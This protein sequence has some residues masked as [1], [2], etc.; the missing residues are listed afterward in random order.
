MAVTKKKNG[1]YRA[2][3][4]VFNNGKQKRCRPSFDR[5]KDAENFEADAVKS[6]QMRS[7]FS[8]LGKSLR[9]IPE[10]VDYY[11][12]LRNYTKN[13]PSTKRRN[14]QILNKMTKWCN[15]IERIKYM[16]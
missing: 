6:H 4:Y 8:S 16:H 12:T 5:K 9:S 15:D 14:D 7:T 13:K 3:V 1:K 10:A 2:D 11:K